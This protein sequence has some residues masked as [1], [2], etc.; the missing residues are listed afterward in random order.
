[1]GGSVRTQNKMIIW[2]NRIIVMGFGGWM[3]VATVLSYMYPAHA[4]ILTPYIQYFLM[5][6]MVCMGLTLEFSDYFRAFKNFKGIVVIMVG[7]FGIASF[8]AWVWGSVIYLGV[9]NNTSLF[10]GEV[11]EGSVAGG[12]ATN[13]Q[14]WLA[15]GDVGL[16]VTATAFGTLITPLVT[17]LLTK[18]YAGAYVPVPVMAMVKQTI[19]LAIAPVL[20]GSL[21]RIFIR[22]FITRIEPVLGLVSCMFIFLVTLGMVAPGVPIMKM[23]FW[24][25]GWAL[26]VAFLHTSSNIIIGYTMAAMAKMPEKQ[27]RAIVFETTTH[28]SG[29]AAVLALANFG[30]LAAVPIYMYAIV[31][32]IASFS[33]AAYM[34]RYP[35][36][37]ILSVIPGLR[38]IKWLAPRTENNKNV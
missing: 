6:S 33:L 10:V 26:L 29:L 13:V 7:T 22:D 1:M 17:P 20:A 12:V 27:S 37:P 2:L 16:S 36:K 24:V 11:L 3:I 4:K 38:N 23:Q 9:L 30:P 15:H 34:M 19:M 28:N 31:M 21:L 14:T 8:F 32:N 5:A 35:D 18:F 25:L